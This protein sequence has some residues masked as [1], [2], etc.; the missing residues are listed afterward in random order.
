[1]FNLFSF[2]QILLWLE[3]LLGL[4]YIHHFSIQLYLLKLYKHC[5]G[6][7]FGTDRGKEVANLIPLRPSE[8]CRGV[9]RKHV[10]SQ[11]GLTTQGLSV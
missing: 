7:T 8:W 11:C 10:D 3:L 1:M 9:V 6:S 4:G 5:I 2:E